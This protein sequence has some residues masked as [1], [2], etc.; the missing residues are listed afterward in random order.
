MGPDEIPPRLVILAGFQSWTT[1]GP[2]VNLATDCRREQ[3][4]Q[5]RNHRAGPIS[6][7]R[8]IPIDRTG[9]LF[10]QKDLIMARRVRHIQARPGEWIKVHRPR[11]RNNFN[12]Y[13]WIIIV[14]FLLFQFRGC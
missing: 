6:R 14:I 10:Q 5:W 3:T 8:I 2:S 12:D 9:R 11:R 4:A 13:G 7:L 1:R